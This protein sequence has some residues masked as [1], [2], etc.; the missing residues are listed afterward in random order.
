MA[1]EPKAPREGKRAV[2]QFKLVDDAIFKLGGTTRKYVGTLRKN[3]KQLQEW[4]KAGKGSDAVLKAQAQNSRELA[5]ALIETAA[6]GATLG[7]GL[8]KTKQFQDSTGK[9]TRGITPMAAILAKASGGGEKFLKVM[10]FVN[11]KFSQGI[12]AGKGFGN[13]MAGMGI[14]GL[15]LQALKTAIGA[16]FDSMK[17]L[18]RSVSG[19]GVSSFDAAGFAS[20]AA[21]AQLKYNASSADFGQVMGSLTETYGINTAAMQKMGR[22]ATSVLADSIGQFL[23]AAKIMG[24]SADEAGNL[25]SSLVM[26]HF[27]VKKLPLAFAEFRRMLTTTEMTQQALAEALGMIAPVSLTSRNAVFGLVGSLASIRTAMMKSTNESIKFAASG[28]AGKIIQDVQMAFTKAASGLDV[29]KMLAFGGGAEPGVD[30]WEA[31]KQAYS[32]ENTRDKVLMNYFKRIQEG[33]GEKGVFFAAQQ[34]GFSQEAAFGFAEIF[35]TLQ[36]EQTRVG[37]TQEEKLAAQARAMDKVAIASA[38]LEDPMQKLVSLVTSI[39]TGLYAA[40]N[41]FKPG[42]GTELANRTTQANPA[43]K[44]LRMAAGAAAP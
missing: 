23:G 2:Q 41:V 10:D 11:P 8:F 37:A 43:T 33:G 40:I 28:G 38:A 18:N 25:A 20:S 31:I 44:P 27:D 24:M 39:L 5:K 13:V 14:A 42:A 7:K 1:D 6:G 4:I 29:A 36:R 21:L 15:V 9:F 30:T 19:L 17:M 34:E 3:D 35:G 22:N 16:T 32:T 26:L 12:V